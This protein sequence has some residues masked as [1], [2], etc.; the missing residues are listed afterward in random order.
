MRKNNKRRN[1]RKPRK[2]WTEKL[3]RNKNGIPIQGERPP[4][5][6]VFPGERVREDER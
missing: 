1:R 3:P 6:K 5:K 4:R 2:H